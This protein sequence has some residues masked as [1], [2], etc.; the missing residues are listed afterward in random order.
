MKLIALLL[1][2]ADI[3]V[4]VL[5]GVHIS[6]GLGMTMLAAGCGLA[7]FLALSDAGWLPS[8]SSFGG[9]DS[10][11]HASPLQQYHEYHQAEQL[12]ASTPSCDT[13]DSSGTADYD[14][15]SRD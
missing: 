5:F 9:S 6:A 4:L 10:E 1:L 11:A 2:I 13:P 3:M 8:R 7:L 14:C 12:R 15:T